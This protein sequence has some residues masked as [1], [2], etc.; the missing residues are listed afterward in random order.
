MKIGIIGAGSFGM[1]LARHI[2]K[3]NNDIK[4]WAYDEKEVIQ[5]NEERRIKT[6]PGVLF[7]E[8][9]LV[10]NNLEEVVKDRD[11][12]LHVTPSAFAKETFLKYY[13]FMKKDAKIVICSKGFDKETK[14]LPFHIFSAYMPKENIAV[15]TGPTHA[16]EV[17]RDVISAMV[18]ASMSET[19]K[20]EIIALFNTQIIRI[21]KTDDII[22]A[23]TAGALKNIIALCAGIIV[24]LGE[25]DNTFAALCTRG[26]VEIARFTEKMGGNVKTVYGLSG[27]GDLIVTCS[28]MHSRNRR[29]GM[30]LAKGKNLQEI[31]EE[32]GMVIE[33]IDN[34]EVAKE[35]AD[36]MEIEMPIVEAVYNVL[37]K[38]RDLKE[39]IYGLM[40][41]ELREE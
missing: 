8:N 4:V 36:E 39:E 24:E 15:L 5:I 27:L 12:L 28:S 21:Y 22:G 40:K 13:K 37:F 41:R 11:I 7:D 26:L 9:I 3:V 25:G 19:L 16:E 29:A 34:I 23:E 35:L 10:S 32:I 33:S 18:V 20:N 31:R 14:K 1:A 30:L 2:N 6:L 38:D 17:S